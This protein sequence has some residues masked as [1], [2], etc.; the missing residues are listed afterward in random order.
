MISVKGYDNDRFDRS[1]RIGWM[2]LERIRS[3]RCLVAGAGALGNE[4]VKCLVLSGF[5]DITVVDMDDVV[6]SNLNRCVF[7]REG[8]VM[9]GTKSEILAARASEIDQNVRITPRCMKVQEMDDWENFD[10]IIGCLDNITARLHVN[11][12]AYYFK[13]P[14]VDGGTDGMTGKVQTV[15]PGGP[16]LQCSMNKSHYDVTE[17]RFSCTGKE[18]VFYVPKMAAEI[19]TTSVIA[20][21]QL[22]EAVKIASGC[23][24]RCVR[25]AAYYDGMSGETTVVEIKR[26]D[27]C[28]NHFCGV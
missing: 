19:T 12:N 2:D 26:D 14:Y 5:R 27:G 25:N 11:A 16:C 4:A 7:F 18:S 23:E 21:M 13:I 17:A 3:A 10:L 24:N 22:R 28:D 20:A 15:L 1:S 9:S 6:T 8:D